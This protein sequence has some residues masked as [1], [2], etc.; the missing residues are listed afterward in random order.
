MTLINAKFCIFYFILWRG[1]VTVAVWEKCFKLSTFW[2]KSD[3][4]AMKDGTGVV[5]KLVD[6]EEFIFTND[7][8]FCS[9]QNKKKTRWSI[10]NFVVYYTNKT[11]IFILNEETYIF[12]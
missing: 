1:F 7:E 12:P 9:N 2:P 10:R 5:S 8:L 11:H 6:E 4:L 3:N